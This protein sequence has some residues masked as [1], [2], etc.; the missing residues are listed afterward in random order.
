MISNLPGKCL[1]M[2][3]SLGCVFIH[4]SVDVVQ[5]LGDVW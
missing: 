4:S 3:A 2:D 5:F 1:D